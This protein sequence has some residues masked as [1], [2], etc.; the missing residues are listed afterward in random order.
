MP[1]ASERVRLSHILALQT[2]RVGQH[3]SDEKW[4]SLIHESLL[5]LQTDELTTKIC[6][7][8]HELHLVP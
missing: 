3:V 8:L 2:L 4:K 5:D 1:R 7:G 6:A